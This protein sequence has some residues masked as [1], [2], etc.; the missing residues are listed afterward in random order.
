M[1]PISRASVATVSI[2]IVMIAAMA[3][4]FPARSVRAA[5][6]DG[7]RKRAEACAACHGRDGNATVPIVPSLAGQPPFYTHW[8]LAL[9]RDGRRKD[10][11]MSPFAVNLS[12]AEMA[13][14]AAYYATQKP[15]PRPTA[16]GDAEAIA[17]GQRL[18]LLHHCASCHAPN[19]AGPRYTPHLAGQSYEYLAKQLR[20]FKARTRG[21]LDG[22]TMTTAVQ[23]LTEQEV[24]I[25]ARYFANL[26]P[27]AGGGQP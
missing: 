2:L 5:D 12:D 13:D 20:E 17:A 9:F 6:V 15:T 26:P 22:G 18:A 25:L 11:Q 1:S 16:P 8:Q 10:P 27:A 24:E 21:E 3:A 4:V 19:L 14:L 7:G 23:P